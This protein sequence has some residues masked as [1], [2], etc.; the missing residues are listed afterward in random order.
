MLK[1]DYE[2]YR[3]GILETNLLTTG[4]QKKAYKQLYTERRW[5]PTLKTQK[6]LERS[7]LVI[8]LSDKT[9]NEDIRKKTKLIDAE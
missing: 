2:K 5:I 1:K 7:M 8:K 4:S 6:T 9:K 3:M